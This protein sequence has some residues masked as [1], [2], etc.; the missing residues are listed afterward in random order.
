[1]RKNKHLLLWSS[2]GVLALLVAAAVQENFLQRWRRIQASVR[3]ASGPLDVRLRQIV[4]PELKATDRCVACHVGM[5]P[6]EQVTGETRLAAAHPPVVHDPAK[7]GCTVCHGGQGRATDTDEA[8][9]NVEFWPEP[10]IPVQYAEAGCGTCHSHLKV[11]QMDVLEHGRNLLERYDCLACHRV[12][13]RGGTLR[14]GA[15]MEGPDLSHVGA[16]GIEPGW[17]AS[18]LDHYQRANDGPWRTSFGPIGKEDREAIERYL[19]SRVGAPELVTAKSLFHSLGCRGCHKINGVGGDDGP[20]LSQ[21][22]QKVPHRLD[23]SHVDGPHTLANWHAEHLR[24]PARIVPGSK[25]P[26]LGLTDTQIEHLTLYMLSLRRSDFPEAYWPPDRLRVERLGEREFSTDGATLFSTF[27][28]ACHGPDGQGRRFPDTPP[29]PAVADPDFLAAA[30][31][32]FLAETIRR[33]RPGRRMPAWRESEGGLR[34]EEIGNIVAHLRVLGGVASPVAQRDERR[35]V[36]GDPALGERLFA[37]HCAGCH[38]PAGESA[39]APALNNRALLETAGD[40]YLVETIRRGRRTAAM[41]SFGTATPARPALSPH[42]IQSTV[43]FIRTW[44]DE[45][46]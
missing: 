7:F 34:D 27:C 44:E 18:H 10:L 41:P 20:D 29:F 15:G 24:W 23:F 32:E 26:V 40:S 35:W 38:G 42:E 8:H 37:R 39:E 2:L 6:G 36:Q 11:P 3:T 13:D 28:A 30:D 21:A 5:T 17:Y 14:P 33:G 46:K 31:D 4:V 16:A 25:M 12:D 22:G 1:M 9:G 43:A 19:G 45:S